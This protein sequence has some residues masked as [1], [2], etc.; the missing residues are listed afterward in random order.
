MHELK[1]Y[2]ILYQFIIY[3]IL[4]IMREI[5]VILNTVLKQSYA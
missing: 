1:E 4:Q 5:I 2:I 3:D